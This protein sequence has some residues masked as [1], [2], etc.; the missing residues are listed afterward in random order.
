MKCYDVLKVDLQWVATYGLNGF[1]LEFERML[2]FKELYC[3]DFGAFFMKKDF[4]I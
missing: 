2:D 1:D 3:R 4:L